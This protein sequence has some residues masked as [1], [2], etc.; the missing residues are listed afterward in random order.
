MMYISQRFMRDIML[1]CVF[2][3][4]E[5]ERETKKSVL[6]LFVSPIILSPLSNKCSKNTLSYL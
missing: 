6:F 5:R 3:V 1:V 4:F 2:L